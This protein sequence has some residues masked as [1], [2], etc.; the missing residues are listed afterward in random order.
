MSSP[1]QPLLGQVLDEAKAGD[2]PALGR[3][4][5]RYRNYLVLLARLRIGRQLQGKLDPED[6]L[7]EVSLEAQKGIGRF[8]GSTEAEFLAWLRVI[9][10]AI[11]SNHLRHYFGTRRRDPRRERQIAADLD[12]SSR[13]L[14]RNL[15]A[16]LTSPS[17][18]AARREQAVLLADALEALPETYREVVILRHLEG[19]TFP[20]VAR[21]MRKT[22]DSVK[23][24]WARGLARLRQTMKEQ[25]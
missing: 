9:M 20:E 21:R 2:R 25:V 8:S 19:L 12:G 10:A 22:E 16:P 5:E 17:Q 4:I 6:L 1:D 23:N 3:L 14:D 7:Q 24:L 15:I 11:L 18:Q 13:A